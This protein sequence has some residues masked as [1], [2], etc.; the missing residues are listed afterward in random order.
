[1]AEVIWEPSPEVLERANVVRFM[2]RHGFDDYREFQQRSQD[3]SDWFWPAAI[4]DMDLDFR[5]PWSEGRRSLARARVGDLV[6][7]RQAEH[8]LELRPPV[9]G[10]DA[11]GGGGR[12]PGRER[13]S[14]HPDLRGAL[15]GGDA[16]RRRA[17]R[18]RCR[19]GRHGRALPPDVARGRDR[20]AR[21]CAPRR[22]PG[23]RLLGLRR[24]GRRCQ[25]RGL[26]G[27]GGRDGRRL[28]ST[29][30][31]SPDEGDSRRGGG[32][33]ADGRARRRLEPA[34]PGGRADE[35]GPR[36]QLD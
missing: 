30:A 1:M 4:E 5:E 35:A 10:A 26:G 34:R 23:A 15:P 3:D 18:A 36:L 31:R 29:R 19:R 13:R 16:V 8:R 17:G 7:R 12:V 11:R 33:G 24:P 9:G 27:E 32:V 28:A 2:R 22:D 25:A 20:L 14:A 6:R 21:L